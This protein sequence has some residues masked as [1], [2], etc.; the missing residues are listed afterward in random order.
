MHLGQHELVLW[1]TI[2]SMSPSQTETKNW[3]STS[4]LKNFLMYYPASPYIFTHWNE[5]WMWKLRIPI[6]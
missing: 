3:K 6:V 4:L 5:H 2:I 1:T